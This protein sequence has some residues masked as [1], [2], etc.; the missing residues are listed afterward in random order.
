MLM[1]LAGRSTWPGTRR[2]MVSV[3]RGPSPLGPEPLLGPP[4]FPQRLHRGSRSQKMHFQVLSQQQ[5]RTALTTF[6]ARALG[7]G[8]SA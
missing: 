4:V 3:L 6:R 7:A 5:K 8:F 1:A 2:I